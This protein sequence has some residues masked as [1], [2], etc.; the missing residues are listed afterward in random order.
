MQQGM[1][2][3]FLNGF[4]FYCYSVYFQ[5]FRDNGPREGF[6]KLS[7]GQ[8]LVPLNRQSQ[9][10]IHY[11]LTLETA[12]R[13]IRVLNRNMTI[14]KI[15]EQFVFVIEKTVCGRNVLETPFGSFRTS[16]LRR[17]IYLARLFAESLNCSIR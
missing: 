17:D 4:S 9:F 12:R 3:A 11:N 8:K 10:P 5:A 1:Y 13:S 14:R 2:S 7:R 6:V 15:I 16:K